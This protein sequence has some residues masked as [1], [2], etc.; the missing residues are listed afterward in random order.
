MRTVHHRRF[1]IH[2]LFR[3]FDPTGTLALAPY[4]RAV[5]G[6]SCIKP[7]APLAETT[8]HRKL[9]S[10]ATMLLTKAVGTPC[11]WAAAAISAWISS[12]CIACRP[13]PT[14]E[15]CIAPLRRGADAADR[16]Q[17]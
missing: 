2:R 11:F 6:V 17:G 13:W 10:V 9:D 3:F 4:W 7:I 16:L 5:A 14:P 12:I 8:L 15:R 1:L